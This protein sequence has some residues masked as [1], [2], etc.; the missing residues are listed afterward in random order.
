MMRQAG[1][2]IVFVMAFPILIAEVQRHDDMVDAA[3]VI[4][5]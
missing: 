2:A 5:Q 3:V 4:V 1:W